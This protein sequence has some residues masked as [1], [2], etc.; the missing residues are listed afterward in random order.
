M[1]AAEAADEETAVTT[2]HSAPATRRAPVRPDPGSFK[3]AA[4]F[5]YEL[6]AYFAPPSNVVPLRAAPPRTIDQPKE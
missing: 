3:T 4:P 2:T 6:P 5:G 1:A